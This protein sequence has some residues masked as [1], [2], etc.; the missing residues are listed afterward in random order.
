MFFCAFI[1]GPC[2]LSPEKKCRN[3]RPLGGE[4]LLARASGM[5]TS[6]ELE[7]SKLEAKLEERR[8]VRERKASVQRFLR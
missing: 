7:A 5:R 3:N 4:R 1:F 2:L 6:A 8:A